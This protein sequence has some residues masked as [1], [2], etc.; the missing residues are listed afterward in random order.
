MVSVTVWLLTLKVRSVAAA[1]RSSVAS[2]DVPC[3]N[4]VARRSGRA[5]QVVSGRAGDRGG[6]H[7]RLRGI[8]DRSLQGLVGDRLGAVDE[9]LQRGDAG[10]GG[11]QH[12]HAVADA[13]QQVVDVAGAVVER[14]RREE[15]G[16]I[17]ESSVDLLAG[18]QAVL[19]G[20]EQVS[21]RLQRKQVLTDRCRKN[22]AGHTGYPSG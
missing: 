16:R 19:R 9:L 4:G 3:E 6:R 14:L 13:V 22:D 21:G 18:G 12:L 5:E 15:V 17:V 8:A 10:V 2:A 11:L 1:V 7:R 20:G